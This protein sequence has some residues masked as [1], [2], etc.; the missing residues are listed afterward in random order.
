MNTEK[1]NENNS[2]DLSSMTKVPE[3]FKDFDDIVSKQE[4]LSN[5][6]KVPE[7]FKGFI[8]VSSERAEAEA[9]DDTEGIQ[10]QVI[11]SDEKNDKR[12][13]H[14]VVGVFCAFL[15]F[16]LAATVIIKDREYSESENRMLAQ[17]PVLT[18]ITLTDGS[19]MKDFESYLT[20]QFPV[21]DFAISLKT[22]VDRTIGI[23]RENSVYIG[24]EGFLFDKPTTFDKKTTKNKVL[25]MST[26]AA[27][28]PDIKKAVLISPN[29]SYVYSDKLP[30]NLQLQDQSEIL[31]KIN[32]V[33]SE[34]S[35]KMIDTVSIMEKAREK[36]DSTLLFYK[37][38]HHW[39][40]RGAYEAF[41]E[42]EKQWKLKN[43]DINHTFYTVSESFEGTLGSKAGVHDVK[44]KI[45]ICI[46]G[47]SLGT[48]VVNYESQQKKKATLFE[49]EKLEQKNQYEIF[50]GGN[51]DKVSISTTAKTSNTLLLIKDSY[52]NCM[53][54]MLTAHFS[55]IVVLDPRYL[56]D[57]MDDIMKENDFT[58]M[59][60]L[61]NLN[62][63]LEDTSLV[64]A[65]SD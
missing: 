62:T 15:C 18:L 5:M 31:S 20:D 41:K 48:Y 42:L 33:I 7:G 30:E 8:D 9:T 1:S 32:K 24:K 28:Y 17:K 59:L 57:S 11:E 54:P 21:R 4:F 12:F 45:E 51:Y 29:S 40:T 47:K 19:F 50:L 23:R 49:N 53:I 55:K 3:N 64:D 16:V 46:P 60:F 58:H 52:A 10:E 2:V 56:T 34:K 43:K 37:T 39:S 6:H 26:F 61:Y 36:D 65:L 13:G 63:F 38:D 35:L 27:K 44:D 14:I 22:F 25:A